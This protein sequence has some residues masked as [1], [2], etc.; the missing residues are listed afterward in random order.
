MCKY[1]I[2][3]INYI[4]ITKKLIRH[5][6]PTEASISIKGKILHLKKRIIRKKTNLVTNFFSTICLFADCTLISLF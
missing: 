5:F 2:Y 3:K 4:I 6:G 1:F